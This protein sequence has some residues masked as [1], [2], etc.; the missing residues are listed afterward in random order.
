MLFFEEVDT[1]VLAKFDM[2]A[3]CAASPPTLALL[4]V[5]LLH[6][7][8]LLLLLLLPLLLP[9][10]LPVS[11][12]ARDSRPVSNPTDTSPP[13]HFTDHA[14]CAWNVQRAERSGD[15]EVHQD[16]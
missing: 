10:K 15:G 6:L 11:G 13:A 16:G 2:Q 5:V 4:L 7:L 14:S 1:A 3:P 9:P 8:L 12:W